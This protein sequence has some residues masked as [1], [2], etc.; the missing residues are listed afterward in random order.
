M[1]DLNSQTLAEYDGLVVYAN[2]DEISDDQARALLA[3][4]EGG[5]GFIP[6]HCASYCFPE[7]SGDRGIDRGQFLRHETACSDH[8]RGA[9]PSGDERVQRV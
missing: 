9:G 5:K 2:I 8:D 1:T 3:F 4:V 6:L 7:S